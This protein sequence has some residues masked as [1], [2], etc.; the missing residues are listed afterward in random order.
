[1]EK[2]KETKKTKDIKQPEVKKQKVET[3]KVEPKAKA[4]KTKGAKSQ[5]V[6]HGVGRRKRA[7][8]RVWLRRGKG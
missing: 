7:V 2:T 4:K 1:M 8:A 3:K 6:S 5:V